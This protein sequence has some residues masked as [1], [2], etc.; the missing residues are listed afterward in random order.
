MA[1]TFVDVSLCPICAKT[2]TNSSLFRHPSPFLS[3]LSNNFLT[4]GSSSAICFRLV[5]M[6]T[7]SSNVTFPSPICTWKEIPYVLYHVVKIKWFNDWLFDWL[8]VSLH[9]VAYILCIFRNWSNNYKEWGGVAPPGPWLWLSLW[10]IV[11]VYQLMFEIYQIFF[12]ST[13]TSTL[14]STMVHGQIVKLLNTKRARHVSTE[15]QDLLLEHSD[16]C[17]TLYQ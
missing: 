10:L 7:I 14:L 16:K 13:F 11:A 9:Q 17:V 8:L 1:S 2:S 15:I 5:V 3:N 4:S 12:S 6:T